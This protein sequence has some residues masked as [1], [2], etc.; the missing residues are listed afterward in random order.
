NGTGRL[1]NM[2]PGAILLTGMVSVVYALE[3]THIIIPGVTNLFAM[4]PGYTLGLGWLIPAAIGCVAGCL[5]G[6]NRNKSR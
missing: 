2:Y 4:I 6:K 5:I 3:Q 1:K